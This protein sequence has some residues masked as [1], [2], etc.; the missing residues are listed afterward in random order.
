MANEIN[1]NQMAEAE[2]TREEIQVEIAKSDNEQEKSKMR[3]FVDRVFDKQYT[4]DQY[5]VSK[6]KMRWT[7][8]WTKPKAKIIFGY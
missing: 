6:P 4:F 5:P 7:K 8:P 1:A 3:N 2:K